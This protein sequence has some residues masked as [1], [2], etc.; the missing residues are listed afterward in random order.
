M[1]GRHQVC[2]LAGVRAQP[3]QPRFGNDVPH[4]NVGVL[5]AGR[6]QRARAIVAQGSHRAAVARQRHL[7]AL[8]PLEQLVDLVS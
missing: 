4:N 1:P 6:Q 5:R 3:E 8:M 2:H 7:H